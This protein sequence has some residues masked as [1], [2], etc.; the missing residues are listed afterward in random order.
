METKKSK[1]MIKQ[2]QKPFSRP[3]YHFKKTK[4]KIGVS[5][6]LI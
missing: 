5:K 2:G 6:K 4:K 1:K 3:K